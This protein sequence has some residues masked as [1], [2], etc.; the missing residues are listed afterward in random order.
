MCSFEAMLVEMN[1]KAAS[2]AEPPYRALM[3]KG[4]PSQWLRAARYRGVS[5]CNTV[6]CVLGRAWQLPLSDHRLSNWPADRRRESPDGF[7]L[8]AWDL[9]SQ[10][11]LA[12]IL[13]VALVRRP[14]PWKGLRRVQRSFVALGCSRATNDE[15]SRMVSSGIASIILSMELANCSTKYRTNSG[16]S[17]FLSRSGGRESG[18]IF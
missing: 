17:A 12:R 18:K 5:F 4:Q 7:C 8:P 15:R 2:N 10:S 9:E 16:I 14:H 1:G 13:R 11:V 6:W 3:T